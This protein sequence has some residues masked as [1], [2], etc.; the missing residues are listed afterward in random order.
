MAL[1]VV[2]EPLVDCVMGG[3]DACCLAYRQAGAGK[4]YTMAG[5]LLPT[6]TAVAGPRAVDAAATAPPQSALRGLIPR[7][8][9]KLL[10][11]IG[12]M[13]VRSRPAAAVLGAARCKAC[14]RR[15]RRRLCM[16]P[17]HERRRQAYERGGACAS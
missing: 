7:V 13:Q 14:E 1:A 10:G 15:A 4:T 17:V 2:G 8:F 11:D 16:H 9:E 6:A 5:S 3:C 12:R